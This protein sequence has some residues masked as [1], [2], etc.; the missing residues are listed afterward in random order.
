MEAFLSSVWPNL[1]GFAYFLTVLLFCGVLVVVIH[2]Q[3]LQLRHQQVETD[4][5]RREEDAARQRRAREQRET[6]T[7]MAFHCDNGE[8]VLVRRDQ[9]GWFR[10]RVYLREGHHWTIPKN[11]I[12]VDGSAGVLR[13]YIKW[14]E[15]GRI[16]KKMKKEIPSPLSELDA[17]YCEYFHYLTRRRYNKFGTDELFLQEF[18]LCKFLE[19]RRS[20]T[21]GEEL[22]GIKHA[23]LT[24]VR[25]VNEFC[26]D[27]SDEDDDDVALSMRARVL[28]KGIETLFFYLLVRMTCKQSIRGRRQSRKSSVFQ[29]DD[30]IQ[31]PAF[32]EAFERRLL[33]DVLGNQDD[34][35][36]NT[37]EFCERCGIPLYVFT[38][39][40]HCC[41]RFICVYCNV[42]RAC[43]AFIRKHSKVLNE[44]Y[45]IPTRTFVHR[46]RNKQKKRVGVLSFWSQRRI[47]RVP[48]LNLSYVYCLVGKPQP[49]EFN[50]FV[51]EDI[52]SRLQHTVV[53]G[54]NKNKFPKLQWSIEEELRRR[55]NPRANPIPNTEYAEDWTD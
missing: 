40:Y 3:H 44:F 23:Y 48:W 55:I 30:T 9:L 7:N 46:R 52:R 12:I 27:D 16:P 22:P 13:A 47:S 38:L 45:T 34:A 49:M 4:R 20:L 37:S 19:V 5:Q 18:L 51:V 50:D 24:W 1:V 25:F 2:H 29:Q 41:S 42:P 28:K 11:G 53:F 54:V 26:R 8:V 43:L 15:T 21:R 6:L 36:P 33:D 32:D 10:T 17:D 14:R 39:P 35:W 31:F